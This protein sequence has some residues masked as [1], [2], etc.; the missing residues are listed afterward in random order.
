LRLNTAYNGKI[1]Q[2]TLNENDTTVNLN[3][4]EDS[5]SQKEEK[6]VYKSAYS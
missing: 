6:A 4:V 2:Y 1:P 5:K 3:T